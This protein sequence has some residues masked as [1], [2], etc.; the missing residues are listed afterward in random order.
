MAI[1]E[2]SADIASWCKNQEEIVLRCLSK[3]NAK[4]L[5]WLMDLGRSR[6]AGFLRDMYVFFPPS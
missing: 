4:Q 1:E 6:G 5:P 2:N 3:L